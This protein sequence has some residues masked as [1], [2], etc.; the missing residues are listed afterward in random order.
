M[1]HISE[2]IAVP[3]VDAVVIR[4]DRLTPNPAQLYVAS[5]L[6]VQSR[7]T[8]IEAMGRILFILNGRDVP[9]QTFPWHEVHATETTLIRAFLVEHYGPATSRL[10]LSI[11]RGILR[12]CFR[13]EL[14][15]ADVYQRA[16][17]IDPVRGESA[18]A[19]RMLKPE[20]I[21]I[22]IEY[23]DFLGGDFGAMVAAL[24]AVGLGGGLRREE[25]AALEATALADDDSVV[26]LIGKGQKERVQPLPPW[27]GARVRAWLELRGECVATTMFLRTHGVRIKDKEP[28]L[29]SIWNL[30]GT[31][32][33]D[34]GVPAFTPHDLR[35]TF[36]SRMLDRGDL[37]LAQKAM[38]HKSPS[39]T[40]RYDRREDRRV[41]ESVGE[42]EGFGFENVQ[43]KRT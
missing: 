43:G 41:A 22:L 39:T 21:R 32:G 17:M 35:R 13:L 24:F 38:A 6:T 11:L 26:R 19:G 40:V 5:L 36:A 28:S 29:W 12:Q 20:E 27:A 15:T 30:I 9:W 18:P 34:A 37:S 31:T 23:I 25:M 2:G 7:K 42:L 33:R 8:A 14:I 10:T 3:E 4:P 1:G 16:I